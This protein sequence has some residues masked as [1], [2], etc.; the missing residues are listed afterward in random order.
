MKAVVT[1]KYGP[2]EVLKLREVAKPVPG[3]NEVL[4]KVYATTVNRTDCGIRSGKPFLIRFFT[5]LFKHKN[6][7]L[8]TEFAG[9]VEGVGKNVSLF[10]VGE[11]VFGFDDNSLGSHAQYL[12]IVEDT[13]IMIIPKKLT[14]EQAA[15]SIEGAH[16]A[17]NFINKV[18]L[19]KGQKVLVNGATEV[20]VQQQFKF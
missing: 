12:T 7:I 11:K 14:F 1:T 15:A 2:P 17:Y 6:T 8:G 16:Y 5:G 4:V 9:E 19:K 13:T 10:K 3:E 18:N 20:L